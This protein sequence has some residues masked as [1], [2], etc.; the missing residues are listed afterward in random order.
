MPLYIKKGDTVKVTSGNDRGKTGKV[1]SVN[2]NR[3]TVTVEKVH[4]AKKH[5]KPSNT[6]PT[7]G[8]IEKN[9]P[10]SIS[11]VLLFCKNCNRGVRVGFRFLDD[12]SKVRYCR[13][14]N[15]VI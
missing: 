8:I 4:V 7:G 9:L 6:S 14:C 15:E 2:P 12:G 11:N 3:R 13:K 1:I 5:T 10:I